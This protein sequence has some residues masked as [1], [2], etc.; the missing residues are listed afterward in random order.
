M[1]ASLE[2]ENSSLKTQI[3]NSSLETSEV[4]PDKT[5]GDFSKAKGVYWDKS[6]MEN[7][8]RNE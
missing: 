5:E 2:L 1:R 6:R 8:T 7:Y 4:L 3:D